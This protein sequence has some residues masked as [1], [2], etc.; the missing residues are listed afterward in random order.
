MSATCPVC[1]AT[2]SAFFRKVDGY[3]YFHCDSCDSLHI[4]EAT[5]EAIDA[6]KHVRVYDTKYWSSELQAARQRS[7]GSS[8]VRAGE[9]ILYAR[10]PITAFLDVGT[11]PGYLL[12]SLSAALP[13]HRDIFHGVELFPPESHSA[14]PNYLKG[15]LGSLARTFDAGVCIEVVEHLTPTML[16]R[17]IRALAKVSAPKALWLFNTGMPD[18]VRDQ[19]PDYLDPLHRGH[20]VSYGHRALE[21][22]FSAQGFAFK[23]IPGKNYA[24]LAEY[25][26]DDDEWNFEARIH[27]PLAENKAMLDQNGLLYAASFEAARSSYYFE[28]YLERT[29]W[30]LG[31]DD[32][33]RNLRELIEQQ[34]TQIHSL[35]EVVEQQA[36]EA[37]PA[38]PA[39]AQARQVTGSP[40]MRM[41]TRLYKLVKPRSA[42]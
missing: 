15:D 42:P 6:G 2:A 17:L 1:S 40:L 30:A 16:R 29:R 18:Y 41:A 23:V 25:Q 9:C 34:A 21:S 28:Q 33:V 3:D 32:E 31:L 4:D 20:I 14:H 13:L 7:T 19:D 27:S 8:L 38:E 11:G 26:S 22:M 35:Q 36:A 5:I 39:T 10:R 37:Q 24:F 12:D